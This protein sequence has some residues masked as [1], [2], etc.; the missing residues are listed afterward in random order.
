MAMGLAGT[1]LTHWPVC[2]FDLIL[3]APNVL[4]SI[5]APHLRLPQCI[6]IAFRMFVPS[7]SLVVL[8][9]IVISLIN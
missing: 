3:V 2:R 5:T 8:L 6:A 9:C 1:L 4:T 7:V